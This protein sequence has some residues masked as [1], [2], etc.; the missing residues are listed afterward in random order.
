MNNTARNTRTNTPFHALFAAVLVF[1]FVS[2]ACGLIYQVVWTRKLVLLFGTTSYA[3]ST[4]LSIFFIGLALGSLWGGR[5]ADRTARPL[6]LYGVFEIIVGV[7]ALLFLGAVTYGEAWGAAL[8]SALQFGR[9]GGVALRAALALALLLVPVALMGATLPLLAKFVNREIQVRGLRIGALYT[10]NTLGAVTGC[11]LSGFVLLPN[12][13]YTRTTLLGAAANVA[14]GILSIAA[15]WRWGNTSEYGEAG[16]RPAPQPAEALAQALS[17]NQLRL[18]LTAFGVSGFCAL[19]LEVLWT[20]LLTI[21]FLG[22]TYAYTTML[23]TLL[24]GLAAGGL[25]ASLVVDRTRARGLALGGVMTLTGVLCLFMLGSIA[26]LPAKV[27][28]WQLESSQDWNRIVAGKFQLAFLA[29]FAPTFCFG[30]TFPLVVKI[31]SGARATVGRDVGRLYSVNTFGGVLG[32][33]AGGF[34]LIP[35]LGTHGGILLLA[36]LLTALGLSLM[37]AMPGGRWV[38]GALVAAGVAL[39]ALA[40]MRAPVDVSQALNAAYVPADHRVLF[41]REGVEGTV[42]VTE[43]VTETGGSNRILWINRVQATASIEKGVKMN[44]FQGVLPL[45]F[46]RSPRRVLFMCFGSGITCGTLALHDFERIDAVEI[47]PDVIA[48][49]P[50]FAADNLDVLD[51]PNVRVHIDDGRN[52]LLTTRET[53]DIITF[54]PMPLALAG[55]STFYTEEYY[56]LCLARLSPGGMVSQWVPLHSLNPAVVRSLVFTFTAVFP[57]YCAFFINADLFLIGSNQS[58]RI[59]YPALTQRLSQPA[60]KTALDA[61]G[62][63]DPAEV[64]AGFLMDKAA[65]D[66]YAAG[67]RAM[68]DDRPWAEFLAP[69]LVYLRTV[70]DTLA[71]IQPHVTSP[72]GLLTPNT[73]P[74]DAAVLERRHQAHRNDLAGLRLYYGGMAIGQE[75][76]DAFKQSLDIDPQDFNAQYYLKEI[77]KVQGEQM[78][79]WEQLDDGVKILLDALRYLPDDP[80]LLLILRDTYQAQGKDA[81]AR[82]ISQRLSEIVDVHPE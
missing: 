2:G 49:A 81:P 35:W 70:Q 48:A 11:F 6:L 38:R 46:D 33:I 30:M 56:R 13:G 61:V 8:L 62:L 36:A 47:S 58:L 52:F 15:G 26:D 28:D 51:R 3:V 19:A 44:R 69:K 39:F 40:W 68:S 41:Y 17:P 65:L 63:R 54:E 31:L 76:P 27:A 57:E 43:P 55:V 7:W 79:R 60:I 42:A 45:L 23:T 32:A 67:G 25:A 77:V 66:A 71:E 78:L 75:T 12:L 59:D 53:Y 29:L 20:R 80:D 37:L 5:L 82:E 50:L 1:F 10:V 74:E 72:A 18:A 64:A 9:A 24:C 34:V 14:I 22:T 16:Q 21:V 4:V 73:P